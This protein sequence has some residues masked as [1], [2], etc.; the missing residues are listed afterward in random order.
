LIWTFPLPSVD[1]HLS[2][3]GFPYYRNWEGIRNFVRS[4]PEIVAYSTNENSSISNYYIGL[5]KDTDRA[6]LY[7]FIKRPQSYLEEITKDKLTYW[8]GK[9]EPDFTLTKSGYDMVRLY[10]ME[11]GSAQE[12]IEKGF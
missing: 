9:Y 10:I 2:L 6:G 12:I 5:E 8:T 11:P 1:Y 7:I 4:H 3:F